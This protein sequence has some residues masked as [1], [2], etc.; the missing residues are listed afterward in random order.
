MRLSVRPRSRATA[1][2]LSRGGG[3]AVYSASAGG[4][5]EFGPELMVNGTLASGDLTGY[6]VQTLGTGTTEYSNG[7]IHLVGTDG[8]NRGKIRQTLSNLEIG[9]RYFL[10]LDVEIVSG[11][12]PVGIDDNASDTTHQY[13]EGSTFSKTVGFYWV[14]TAVTHYFAAWNNSSAGEGYLDNI[15][16]RRVL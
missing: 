15:S 1:P 8:S 6:T 4:R 5:P 3:A 10:L 13:F 14:A 16:V 7:R 12:V 11:N 9:A 2:G